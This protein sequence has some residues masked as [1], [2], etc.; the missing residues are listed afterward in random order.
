MEKSPLHS[1]LG[2]DFFKL[3]AFLTSYDGEMVTLG[4]GGEIQEVKS[5]VK[6]DKPVFYLKDFYTSS[7]LA[8]RPALILEC[9]REE[10][11]EYLVT[12]K[13]ADDSFKAISDAD[14][15]YKKD[16]AALKN[17]F[18]KDLQKAVLISR[19]NYSGFKG[20]SS[21]KR[22]MKKSFD[23]GAGIP[24]GFWSDEYGIMGTTP[25]LL[26]E[27]DGDF[28][29]TYAL[30]GTVKLGNEKELASKK[31][32]IEHEL[33]IKDIKEKLSNFSDGIEVEETATY[34]FK[35]I[36]HLK[37]DITA[38]VD[39]DINLTDLTN[40]F[41]P[42]A[43]LGGYPKEASLNFLKKT[44]YAQKNG[45][46]FFGSCFGLVS[47]DTKQFIVAIRNVQWNPKELYIECGGGI[48]ADSELQNEYE[49]VLLK[50]DAIKKH[51]L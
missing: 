22:F 37:T 30:A 39:E 14:E 13:Y 42:T 9:T 5:F 35:N 27:V 32:R 25:E 18:N 7:Y 15:T 31:N 19:E 28:L 50:R 3:G 48:V 16:F 20:E 12:L 44:D 1:W 49:E 41:S 51:Y 11:E 2:T 43:A 33:V 38:V 26:Y 29:T 21:I 10:F 40:I 34:P 36:V 47:E 6:T 46:R 4:K 17:A 24:Y 45:K 23:F 8:Y